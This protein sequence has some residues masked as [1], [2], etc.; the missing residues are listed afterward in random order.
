VDK[1]PVRSCPLLRSPGI[2]HSLA[3]A[4]TQCLRLE[5]AYIAQDSEGFEHAADKGYLT[6]RLDGAV[7]QSDMWQAGMGIADWQPQ[8]PTRL[9]RQIWMR[10]GYGVPT[11]DTLHLGLIGSVYPAPGTSM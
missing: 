9:Q 2:T 11:N 10:S 1:L 5:H 6:K 8:V 3:P 4:R 7:W